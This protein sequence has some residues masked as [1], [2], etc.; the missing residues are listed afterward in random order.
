MNVDIYTNAVKAS[1]LSDEAKERALTDLET[2]DRKFIEE[3]EKPYV[4]GFTSYGSMSMRNAEAFRNDPYQAKSYTAGNGTGYV[5]LIFDGEALVEAVDADVNAFLYEKSKAAGFPET[6]YFNNVT[7]YMV[8]FDELRGSIPEFMRAAF[9]EKVF[10]EATGQWKQP[11]V[12]QLRWYH[13]N[14]VDTILR[15]LRHDMKRVKVSDK[16]DS[17]HEEWVDVKI[18]KL[19]F[20]FNRFDSCNMAAPDAKPERAQVTA[21]FS[22][23]DQSPEFK[24]EVS[25]NWHL[26]DTSRWI[27]AGAISMDYTCDKETGKETIRIG[28]NH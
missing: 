10:D 2:Y 18:T 13:T 27:Y 4:F 8:S 3:V 24:P 17:D 15:N 19:S 12:E 23:S 22:V 28:S 20:C 26:Q 6:P 25:W 16:D 9:E 14:E 7:G 5:Y 11:N 1:S 21:F